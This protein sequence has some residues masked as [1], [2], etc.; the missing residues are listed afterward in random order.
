MTKYLERI[1]YKFWNTVV[2]LLSENE[3]I[4]KLVRNTYQFFHNPDLSS[5]RALIGI[6]SLSGLLFGVSLSILFSYVM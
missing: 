6:I 4:R 3:I 2:R 5:D 1:E